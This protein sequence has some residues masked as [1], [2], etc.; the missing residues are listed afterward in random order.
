MDSES[1]TKAYNTRNKNI[2]NTKS[3]DYEYGSPQDKKQS[4]S[5][6][7]S[8]HSISIFLFKFINTYIKKLQLNT[9]KMKIL[10]KS[11]ETYQGK[12]KLRAK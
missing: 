7:K 3:E 10:F 6:R 12:S 5:M 2:P 11:L 4:L 1:K 9:E 8:I